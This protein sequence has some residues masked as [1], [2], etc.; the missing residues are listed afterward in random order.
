MALVKDGLGHPTLG[1]RPAD[2]GAPQTCP[3]DVACNTVD[4]FQGSNLSTLY[5]SL[6]QV[7]RSVIDGISCLA[8][9]FAGVRLPSHRPYPPNIPS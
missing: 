3:G 6:T 5:T 8:W 1:K 7:S 4:S 2:D 9:A